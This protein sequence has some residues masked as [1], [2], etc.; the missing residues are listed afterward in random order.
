MRV[1]IIG[2]GWAGLAAAWR[3]AS[4]G[5]PVVLWEMSPQP[6]GRARSGV[7]GPP[8][9]PVELDG[10]QHILIGA[11]TATLR[12][13]RELGVDPD[14]VLHRRPLELVDAGGRGLRLPPGNPALSFLRGLWRHPDWRGAEKWG[15]ILELLRWRLAGFRCEPDI[16]VARWC[17]LSPRVM[18]DWIEPLCVAALNTEAERASA[19]VFL[20]V[21]ADGLFAGPGGSDLLLP[22]RPLHELIPGPAVSAL[23]SRGADVRLHRRVLAIHPDRAPG[24]WRVDDQP[25]DRLIIATSAAEAARLVAP[26]DAAWARS[27]QAL[28]YEPIV[29]TWLEAPGARLVAPMISLPADAGPAQFAFDLGQLGHPWAGGFALVSSAA[30]AWLERGLPALEAAAQGQLLMALE[31]TGPASPSPVLV[32]SVA[33]KRATFRCEAGMVRPAAQAAADHGGLWVAGDHVE[34]PYPSTLEGAVRSGERAARAV[35]NS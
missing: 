13:M 2:G 8:G 10:G 18:A 1:G 27:A 34:G 20:N 23:R 15:V 28:C 6:G 25:V 24:S 35:M 32:R 9:C 33:E 19:Q 14:A 29:T 31:R 22:R 17:R 4:A 5:H 7:R 21:L 3:L 26:W 30:G 12:L 11:Y 16:T